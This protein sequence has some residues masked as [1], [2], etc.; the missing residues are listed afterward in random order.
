MGSQPPGGHYPGSHIIRHDLQT[1]FADHLTENGQFRR[2]VD[3]VEYRTGLVQHVLNVPLTSMFQANSG[4][5]VGERNRT[6]DGNTPAETRFQE[7]IKSKE[8]SRWHT[9]GPS[10][11][12]GTATLNAYREVLQRHHRY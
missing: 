1:I 8:D 3:D 11:V 9:I 10:G 4:E 2:L 6:P 7:H 5:F 12:L